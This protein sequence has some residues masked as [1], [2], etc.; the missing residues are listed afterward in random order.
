VYL[1]TFC[2]KLFFNFF[3]NPLDPN[4]KK[5]LTVL[6]YRAH[7]YKHE[8]FFDKISTVGLVVEEM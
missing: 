1:I 7:T 6:S 8:F 2:R 4:H 5:V 3:V